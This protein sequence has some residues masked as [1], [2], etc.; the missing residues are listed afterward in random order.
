MKRITV[1]VDDGVHAKLVQQA[2]AD[3]RALLR[4]LERLLAKQADKK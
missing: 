1:M 3:G 4:F 2:K